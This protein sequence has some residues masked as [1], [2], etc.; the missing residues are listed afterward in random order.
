[1]RRSLLSVAIAALWSVNSISFAQSANQGFYL[2]LQ[3]GYGTSDYGSIVLAPGVSAQSITDSAA[4]PA[5]QFGYDFNRY[6]ASEIGIEYL[7]KIKFYN[8]TSDTQP[9]EKIKN[10]VVYLAA[11][12]SLPLS[13]QW[14]LFAKGGIGYVVRDAVVVNGVTLLPGNEF[15]CPVYGAGVGYTPFLHWRFETN[16][17]QTPANHSERVPATNFVGIG[18]SYLFL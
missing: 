18:V 4:A 11:K 12:A 5:I 2:G 10:N 14:Q 7:P 1:M 3:G 6:I 8:I 15:A 9:Y 17:L 16:W 13:A